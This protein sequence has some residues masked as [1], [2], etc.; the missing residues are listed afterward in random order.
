M[1][2]NFHKALFLFIVL[3]IGAASI[4]KIADLD[5]WWHLKTGQILL[6]QREFQHTEIYS[7][8]ANGREYVDHEWLFQVVAYL[9]YSA[10]GAAGFIFLKTALIAA[11]YVLAARH[12]LE[13]GAS[14]VLTAGIV[15]VSVCGS[16]QRFIE[17]PEVFSTLYLIVIFLLLD[18]YLRKASTRLLVFVPVM[19][20]VWSNT[21]AAV[22]LGLLLQAV[23][24]CGVTLELISS[25][26]GYPR[27]YSGA[28]RA[29]I[30]HLAAALAVSI[31]ITGLNPDGYRM[32]RV[33]F[34]LT[35]IIDSGLLNNQEWQRT[36]IQSLPLFYLC[37]FFS[38]G[39]Q[40]VNFRRLSWTHLALTIIFAYLALRYVRNTGM[41]GMLMP[42]LVAPYAATLSEKR[43][44]VASASAALLALTLW[45]L[46][47]AFPFERGIGISSTF[48]EKMVRFI[49]EKN[50]QGNLFNSY[51]FGGYLI[52]RLYPERKVFIDGRN[53]VYLPLL[54]K[55]VEV[56]QD[57]RLWKKLLDDSAIEYAVLNYV[58]DLEKVTMMEKNNQAKVV[59]MPFSSTHFPRSRWALVYW[60]DCGMILVRR[61]GLNQNLLAQEYT[62]VFP[63]GTAYQEN[64]VK[65]GKIDRIKAIEE[66]QRK[67]SEDPQCNRAVRILRNIR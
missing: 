4:F 29:H 57:S 15:L 43:I 33:P 13:K 48:P 14:P 19:T 49:V 10:G 6:Q 36:S 62:S 40:I 37:L 52:W 35:A 63:E 55:I 7:F 25:S 60:D 44:P 51:G 26:W 31:L 9:A 22:I 66:L 32:L 20:L 11:I 64:L 45:I 46:V 65:D 41:F 42:F 17:R 54:K 47:S 1:R 30:L 2:S 24:L 18:A 34:E 59:Y 58:D 23:F 16:L 56:R 12:L 8:T 28:G 5:F 27:Y 67:V 53:E 3:L 61:N 21:H 50:M 39:I 38:T